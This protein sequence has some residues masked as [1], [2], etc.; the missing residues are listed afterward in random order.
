MFTEQICVYGNSP[1]GEFPAILETVFTSKYPRGE[2][3]IFGFMVLQSDCKAALQDASGDYQYAV[4][5][6]NV[7]KGNNPK[8][9]PAVICRAMLR[10]EEYKPLVHPTRPP[11]WGYFLEDL[12]D[13]NRRI[14]DVRVQRR[15]SAAG[16][17]SNVTHI[18][19]PR[20][21]EW[22]CIER[23][24]EGKSAQAVEGAPVRVQGPPELFWLKDGVAVSCDDWRKR[25]WP[26]KG[27]QLGPDEPLMAAV[28]NRTNDEEERKW[29][30]GNGKLIER[31]G[32]D[33]AKLGTDDRIRYR[34]ARLR[35]GLNPFL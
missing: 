10:A 11:E 22:E 1:E 13:G 2:R 21:G 23:Q 7:S 6:C 12:P 16:T 5:V 9:K 19:R 28:W 32:E 24:F 25:G 3:L 31:S 26:P 18:R 33:V 4:A 14:V 34:I 27:Y 30:D 29:Q 15:T 20:D 8:S 17:V 35:A